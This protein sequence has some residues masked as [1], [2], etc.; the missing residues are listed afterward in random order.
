MAAPAAA[1]AVPLPD[2]LDELDLDEELR[3][4]GIDLT[5]E[6]LQSLAAAP[7]EDAH[8]LAGLGNGVV[9]TAM[10]MERQRQNAREE[11]ERSWL[12]FAASQSAQ[13]Q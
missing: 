9:A 1:P 11:L 8:W 3:E 4:G 5:V 2:E 13:A 6:S 7:D 10:R 12:P